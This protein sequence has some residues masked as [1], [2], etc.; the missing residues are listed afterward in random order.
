VSGKRKTVPE[1]A[2]RYIDRGW[3]VVPNHVP[4]PDTGGCSCGNPSC[5]SPGKHP[6]SGAGW[7]AGAAD[8]EQFRGRNVAVVTGP[9][10]GNLG[11]VDEDCDEARAAAPLLLEDS[12]AVYG[13]DG[14]E[15]HRLYTVADRAEALKLQ[16]P[17]LTGAGATIIELRWSGRDDGPGDERPLQTVLP[18]SRHPSGCVLEWIR[19]GEPARVTGDDLGAAVRH[20]AAAVLVARYA[21]PKERHALVLLLA[22]L[23]VR[24]GWADDGRVVRFS[25]TSAR[26]CPSA[27]RSRPHNSRFRSRSWSSRKK[28]CVARCKIWGDRQAARIGRFNAR[29]PWHGATPSSLPMATHLLE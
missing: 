9:R 23:L 2:R 17:V 8:P 5:R 19:D 7:E 4:D 24:A 15:T 1:A 12:G 28:P 20:V 25:P 10:S 6:A 18:P 14:R 26:S 13:R 29:S 11:D 22:N 21:R 16:D 3:V 27:S